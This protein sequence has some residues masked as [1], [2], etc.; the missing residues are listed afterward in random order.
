MWS[1]D[2][3]SL[4]WV[5]RVGGLARHSGDL[6]VAAHAR[7]GVDVVPDHGHLLLHDLVELVLVHG[8]LCANPPKGLKGLGLCPGTSD[9]MG[10]RVIVV[11]AQSKGARGRE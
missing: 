9:K 11:L 6:V 7:L 2:D 5:A 4:A 1:L 8:D 10:K 3:G